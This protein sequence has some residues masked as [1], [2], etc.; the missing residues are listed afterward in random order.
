M[1][2]AEINFYITLKNVTTIHKLFLYTWYIIYLEL[3][4]FF[5][6]PGSQKFLDRGE[7]QSSMA[8]RHLIIPVNLTAGY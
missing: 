6:G 7:Y 5:W 4:I 2:A 1:Y 8:I 3:T